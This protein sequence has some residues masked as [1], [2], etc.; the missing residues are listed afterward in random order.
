MTRPAGEPH[1]DD[2]PLLGRGRRLRAGAEETGGREPAEGETTDLELSSGATARFGRLDVT[3]S[4]CRYPV[5]DPSANAY[6]NLVIADADTGAIAFDGWMVA[7]SP[8]LSALDDP[9]YDVW[10]IRCESE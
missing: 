5:A 10:V 7:S 9:R 6:A 8:A 2:G 4:D 1:Q 3:L